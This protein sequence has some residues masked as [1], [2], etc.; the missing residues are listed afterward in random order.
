MH[1]HS[2]APATE[3]LYLL[4]DLERSRIVE[5]MG[6][7]AQTDGT[8]VRTK[9]LKG[10]I[11]ELIVGDHRLTYFKLLDTLY[12]IR[13]FRKQSRKTPSAEI[14]YAEKIYNAIKEIL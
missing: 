9:Q 14:E 10:P 7:L 5:D 2:L 8:S 4:S 11:R 13:G 12:F 1:I 3:Y 6:I